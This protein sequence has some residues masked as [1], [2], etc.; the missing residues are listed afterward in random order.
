MQPSVTWRARAR[1]LPRCVCMC[2]V[3]RRYL[4][5]PLR[6]RESLR[7]TDTFSLWCAPLDNLL[8]SEAGGGGVKEIPRTA[9][10][11]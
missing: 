8:K 5:R 2:V 1:A 11:G 3:K 6:A 4:A 7:A 9:I 10:S